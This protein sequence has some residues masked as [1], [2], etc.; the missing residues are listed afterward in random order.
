MINVYAKSTNSKKIIILNGDRHSL[1]CR[2][3]SKLS[4][5]LKVKPMRFVSYKDMD[6]IKKKNK[7]KVVGPFNFYSISKL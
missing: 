3:R 6:K 2:Q 4:N 1:R 5:G 7:D